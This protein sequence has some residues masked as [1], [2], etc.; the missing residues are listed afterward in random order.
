MCHRALVFSRGRVVAELVG[1]DLSVENLLAEASA[2]IRHSAEAA[3][4]AF[5]DQARD[6]HAVH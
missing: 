1:A 4:A 5:V 2:N 3:A 6:A